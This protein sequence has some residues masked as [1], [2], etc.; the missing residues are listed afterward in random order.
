MPSRSVSKQLSPTGHALLGLLALRRWTTYELCLQV[1]RSLGRFWPRADS[2]LYAAAQALVAHDLATTTIEHQGRRARTTYRINVRG[3][4]ILGGWLE[5]PGR[6]PVLECE[7]LVKLFFSDQAS[8]EALLAQV[9]V[10]REW[11]EATDTA[12]AEVVREYRRGEGPFPERLPVVMLTTRLLWAQATAMLEWAAFA[13]QEVAR[14]PESPSEWPVDD[15]LVSRAT[16]PF[17]HRLEVGV[18]GKVPPS[19]A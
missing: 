12:I 11:A 8:R 1:K 10:I 13:E 16:A 17:L 3:R 4:A 5:E 14:W 7:A 9:R 18:P 6:P 19:A 15:A 2:N